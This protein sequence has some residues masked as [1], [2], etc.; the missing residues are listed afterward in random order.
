MRGV[1]SCGLIV[2][3]LALSGCAPG[4]IATDIK[5]LQLNDLGYVL[6]IDGSGPPLTGQGHILVIGLKKGFEG[7]ILVKEN[8]Q[9]AVDHYLPYR[10]KVEDLRK[11]GRPS[12]RE[13]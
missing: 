10:E 3:A 1:F 9:V 6:C 13:S 11:G 12:G 8:C 4:L 2:L 7:Q 5:D